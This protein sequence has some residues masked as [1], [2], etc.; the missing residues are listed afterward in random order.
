MSIIKYILLIFFIISL[1]VLETSA[2]HAF[3]N[4]S[5]IFTAMVIALINSTKK[6]DIKASFLIIALG[7]LFLDLYSLFPFGVFF[8]AFIIIFYIS[9]IIILPRLRLL[10]SINISIAGAVIGLIYQVILTVVGY[11]YYFLLISD[12]NIVLDK[13]YFLDIFWFVILNSLFIT[14][15]LWIFSLFNQ[16][17]RT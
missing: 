17:A 8:I 7:G 16:R 6:R 2:L 4:L 13:F 3:K 5:F 1:V 15:V 10:N 14:I 9:Y 11:I 12:I